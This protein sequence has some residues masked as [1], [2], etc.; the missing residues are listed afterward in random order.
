MIPVETKH[1]TPVWMVCLE[2]LKVIPATVHEEPHGMWGLGKPNDAEPTSVT[3]VVERSATRDQFPFHTREIG[4]FYLTEA[5]ALVGLAERIG[6]M[7]Q[8][9]QK[10]IDELDAAEASALRRVAELLGDA[11]ERKATS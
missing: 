11:S 3:V 9:Q 5:S 4:V 8:L 1:G 2:D 7:R 6:R 10:A